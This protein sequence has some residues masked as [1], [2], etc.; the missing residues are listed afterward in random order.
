MA[1]KI[2]RMNGWQEKLARLKSK[3]G[4]KAA[5]F[6]AIKQFFRIEIHF[7]YAIDLVQQQ[8]QEPEPARDDSVRHT[9]HFVSLTT[10]QDLS[11][12]PHALIEQLDAQSGQG[13]AKLIH[14][15]TDVYA[16]IDG[17]GV[18]SQ[19]NISRSAVIHVDS[20]TNLDI[21]LAPG[22]VFLGYLF[23]YPQYR[24]MGTA[25]SL[26]GK[27]CKDIHK[28]GYSRIVTHIRSTNAASLNTFRKCGWPRIGWIV[29]SISGRLLL[30]YCP[31]KVGITV[32]AA[33]RVSG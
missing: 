14:N 30:A 19:V 1:D 29:T 3:G 20:P 2:E 17:T 5:A 13:V 4:L 22:D 32:S 12:Y 10:T 9:G 21:C 7:L 23:T 27:V 26:I 28:R 24:G 6:W 33:K 8:A 15:D 25:A 11:L 18:V 31:G 16:L